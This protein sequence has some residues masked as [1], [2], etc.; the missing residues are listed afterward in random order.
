MSAS[1]LSPVLAVR[2]VDAA[3][4]KLAA[5]FG[6]SGEGQLLRLGEQSIMLVAAGTRP[7]HFI[8]MPLDHVAL[9]IA[10]ADDVNRTFLARGAKPDAHFTPDG[11]RDI[12]QFW[13]HGVRFIFFEGPEGAPLEFCARNGETPQGFGHSHYGIRCRNVQEMS[14]AL[15]ARGATTQVTYRLEGP[16]GVVS[17]AFLQFGAVVLELFDEPPFAAP[18]ETGW[19]GLGA[20]Q[21]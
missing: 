1:F 7:A 13:A 18:R 3:R 9:S 17:V 21:A 4:A 10:D 19:I 6:W 20:P 12:P 11:P 2:D 14:S 5:E 8:D 16:A 15:I